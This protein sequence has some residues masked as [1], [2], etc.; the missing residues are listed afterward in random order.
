MVRA[1]L[2]GCVCIE[3]FSL[4]LAVQA[5]ICRPAA[6]TRR[7]FHHWLRAVRCDCRRPPRLRFLLQAG[8]VARAVIDFARL[9]RGNVESRRDAGPIA[10]HFLLRLAPQNFMA[11]PRRQSRRDGAGGIILWTMRELY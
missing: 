3:L 4:P 2:C 9:G 7:R 11:E 5:W 10:V 1:R 6:A 8:N